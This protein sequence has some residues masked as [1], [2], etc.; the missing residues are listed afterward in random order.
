MLKAV[1]DT[2]VIVSSVISKK[3]APFLIIHAWQRTHFALI[4]SENI[5]RE[6][7]RVLSTPK[8]KDTFHLTDSRITRFISTLRTN[9]ILVSGRSNIQ[10]I[11]PDDPSDEMFLAAAMNAGADVIVS[12]DK[13]LLNLGKFKSIPI[14]TPR[15]FLDLL[16][17][18]V[19]K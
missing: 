4:I 15:Q 9:S 6:V 10:G 11:I 14:L 12:G 5:V 16:E 2:N 17:Q 3:G 18:E 7:Q 19:C 8:V 1:L 13:H